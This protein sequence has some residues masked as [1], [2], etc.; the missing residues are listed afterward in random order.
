M[1]EYFNVLL[2]VGIVD[3]NSVRSLNL[4]DLNVLLRG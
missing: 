2:I 4:W 1:V 3:G